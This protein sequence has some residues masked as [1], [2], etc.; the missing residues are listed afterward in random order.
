MH[1]QTFDMALRDLVRKHMITTE[2]AL[3]ASM[4]PEELRKLIEGA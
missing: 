3:N 1:M 4:H 2:E